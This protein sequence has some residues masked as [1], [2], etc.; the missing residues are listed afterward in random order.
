MTDDE[1]K[2]FAV[3]TF[4]GYFKSMREKLYSKVNEKQIFIKVAELLYIFL[5]TPDKVKK[6]SGDYAVRLL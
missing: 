6:I 2:D 4:T 5:M 3:I 1:V